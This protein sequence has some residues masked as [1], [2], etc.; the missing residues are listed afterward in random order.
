[1]S[2]FVCTRKMDAPFF[3]PVLT[4]L[5]FRSVYANIGKK[6]IKA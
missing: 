2:Y 3:E 6:Y 5:G 4:I 1:M